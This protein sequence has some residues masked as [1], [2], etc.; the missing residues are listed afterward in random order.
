MI[1][2]RR[3]LSLI[4]FCMD[5]VI[6]GVP[7]PHIMINKATEFRQ[8]GENHICYGTLKLKRNR[9]RPPK[10]SV[11]GAYQPLYFGGYR[12][13]YERFIFFCTERFVV[14]AF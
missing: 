3:Y 14:M 9:K 4:P 11:V 13:F 6:E 8:G 12:S 5:R 7:K 1:T 10:L 2:I